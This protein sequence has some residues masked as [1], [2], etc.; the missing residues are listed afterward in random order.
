MLKN[1]DITDEDNNTFLDLMEQYFDQSDG[2]EDARPEHSYQVGVTPSRKEK[3]KDHCSRMSKLTS[4][5]HATSPCP[6]EFDPKWRF[7]WRIV[8]KMDGF[9]TCVNFLGRFT[10]GHSI[11]L[12]QHAPGDIFCYQIT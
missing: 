12:P 8:K 10:R 1:S 6:P 7:F 3:A 2:V 9:M 5:N 11:Q 4:G